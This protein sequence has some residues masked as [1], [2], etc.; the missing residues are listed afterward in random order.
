MKE[1]WHDLI[2]FPL[3]LLKCH[4]C[5]KNE[6]ADAKQLFSDCDFSL[7][8]NSTVTV[9]IRLLSSFHIVV[10]HSTKDIYGTG[11]NSL[12]KR[13]EMEKWFWLISILLV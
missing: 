9:S 10:E 1:K 2:P 6:I 7:G 5:D 3:L 4:R 12:T 8:I 13:E 11:P